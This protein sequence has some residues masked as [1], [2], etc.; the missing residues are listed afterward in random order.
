MYFRENDK[1]MYAGP[2]SRENFK[3]GGS[4]FPVWLLVVIIAVIILVGFFLIK[5]LTYKKSGQKFG[6]RFY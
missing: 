5:I 6:F 1:E 4:K 3:F 2:N